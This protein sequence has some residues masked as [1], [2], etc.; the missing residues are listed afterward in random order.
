VRCIPVLGLHGAG[1]A[2]ERGAIMGKTGEADDMAAGGDRRSDA[3]LAVLDDEAG[4]GRDTRKA[5]L[6]T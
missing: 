3:R 5:R 2:A 6:S 4:F 1:N